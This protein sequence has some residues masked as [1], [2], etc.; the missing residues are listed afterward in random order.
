MSLKKAADLTASIQFFDYLGAP[1]NIAGVTVMKFMI[2]RTEFD[3]DTLAIITKDLLSGV[4]VTDSATGKAEAAITASDLN[5]I[6]GNVY[7]EAMC[8]VSGKVVRTD[9]LQANFS[10]NVIKAIT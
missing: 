1:L 7:A 9:T 4:T 10:V 3:N 6:Q 2:K 8:I 5:G